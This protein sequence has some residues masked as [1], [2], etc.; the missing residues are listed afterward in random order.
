MTWLDHTGALLEVVYS[1]FKTRSVIRVCAHFHYIRLRQA[2]FKL[3]FSALMS[4][5]LFKYHC[6]FTEKHN[7]FEAGGLG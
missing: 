1:R 6:N 3:R 4:G 5:I 7:V 2:V